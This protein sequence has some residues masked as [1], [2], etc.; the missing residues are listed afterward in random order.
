MDRAASGAFF[1]APVRVETRRRGQPVCDRVLRI[2]G[3]GAQSASSGLQDHRCLRNPPARRPVRILTRCCSLMARRSDCAFG[4]LTS[5]KLFVLMG[6]R[7][8]GGPS[9]HSF[10]GWFGLECAI[11][12]GSLALS[13]F[14]THMVTGA[15]SQRTWPEQQ[16]PIGETDVSR[17]KGSATLARSDATLRRRPRC[18]ASSGDTRDRFDR[19]RSPSRAFRSLAIVRLWT[20]WTTASSS[21]CSGGGSA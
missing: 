12:G 8:I 13:T 21:P 14:R 4:S 7:F 5:G 15:C 1:R 2:E 3:I 20:R 6:L 10:E 16:L 19:S 18:H 9:F 11:R 17:R